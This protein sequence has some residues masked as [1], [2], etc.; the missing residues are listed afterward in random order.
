MTVRRA[1]LP[2]VEHVRSLAVFSHHALEV[3]GVGVEPRL[4]LAPRG[5]HLRVRAPDDEP[6]DD[7][8]DPG[9]GVELALDVLQLGSRLARDVGRA[10]GHDGGLV[11]RELHSLLDLILAGGAAPL[12]TALLTGIVD[13]GE[14]HHLTTRVRIL[15]VLV[16]GGIALVIRDE[17]H[18][19]RR[20][21]TARRAPGG[22][23]SVAIDRASRAASNFYE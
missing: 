18:A 15:L 17:A 3:R 19:A 4:R 11:L 14:E 6:R 20:G 5:G 1:R 7:A 23:C 2:L 10:R 13:V 16:V 22:D 8:A 21:V 9:H 12:G